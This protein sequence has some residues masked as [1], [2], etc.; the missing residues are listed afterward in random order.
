MDKI[1][2]KEAADTI[3]ADFNNEHADPRFLHHVKFAGDVCQELGVEKS[4]E[5]IAKTMRLLD[6]A[7]IEGHAYND[8]PKWVQNERGERAVVNDE[9]HEEAFMAR[10]APA[11]DDGVP[12]PE[13]GHI[14]AQTGVFTAG[15]KPVVYERD[16]APYKPGATDFEPGG[17]EGMS[18]SPVSDNRV[19]IQQPVTAPVVEPVPPIAPKPSMLPVTHPADE[20]VG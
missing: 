15:T 2:P 1:G 5:N 8:Y 16:F 14:D 7:G 6:K 10:P 20:S 9:E 13:H 17:L 11:D 3:R 4:P 19:N 12:N 18:A